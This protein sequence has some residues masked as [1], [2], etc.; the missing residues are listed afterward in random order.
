MKEGS[1]GELPIA[2]PLEPTAEENAAAIT[3]MIADVSHHHGMLIDEMDSIS[4]A[5]TA[6]STQYAQTCV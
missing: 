3:Q 6:A 2:N 4:E 5:P 1:S